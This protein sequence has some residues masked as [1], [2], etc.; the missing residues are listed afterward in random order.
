MIW[1]VDASLCKQSNMCHVTLK[2]A[3]WGTVCHYCTEW[4]LACEASA[5]ATNHWL[6]AAQRAKQRQGKGGSARA[7]TREQAQPSPTGGPPPPPPPLQPPSSLHVIPSPEASQ[8]RKC[9]SSS[10][11]GNLH[12]QKRSFLPWH[13]SSCGLCKD[14][15]A[16]SLLLFPLVLSLC[17]C[18]SLSLSP[19][20][21]DGCP[22]A[23]C[24]GA[25]HFF[26]LA[27]S[28][29]VFVC[30]YVSVC[31]CLHYYALVHPLAN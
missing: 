30:E 31:L 4:M 24:L 29:G 5:T 20:L 22:S 10:Q 12:A 2:A 14:F 7:E 3:Q 21:L 19:T 8:Q 6:Q 13:S 28:L 11:P 23:S 17:V 25:I 1:T 9:Q 27:L 15:P 26:S 18:L 16:L